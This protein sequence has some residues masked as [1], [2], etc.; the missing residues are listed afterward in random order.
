[1]HVARDVAL[2]LPVWEYS[3]VTPAR[4]QDIAGANDVESADAIFLSC[5]ATTQIEAVTAIEQDLGK[6]VVNSNQSVL[7]GVLKRLKPKL[8]QI[9]PMPHLGRLMQRL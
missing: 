8:G 2:H 9:E 6:P 4:W 1:M 5:A 3:K 7:W